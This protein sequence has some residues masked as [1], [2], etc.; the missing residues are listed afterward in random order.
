MILNHF[1]KEYNYVGSIDITFK[2]D[3]QNTKGLEES[4]IEIDGVMELPE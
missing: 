1:Q 3:K 4:L 2:L